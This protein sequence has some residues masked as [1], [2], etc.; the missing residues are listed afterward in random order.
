[1]GV[2]WLSGDAPLREG[3]PFDYRFHDS[4]MASRGTVLRLQPPRLL[5]HSWFANLPPGS[6]VRWALAAHGGRLDPDPAVAGVEPWRG[7]R[8]TG[9]ARAARCLCRR[10][11]ARGDPRRQDHRGERL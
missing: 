1:M 8:G 3:G 4:D 11:P 10:L 2:E 7:T 5:E 9:L 6:V